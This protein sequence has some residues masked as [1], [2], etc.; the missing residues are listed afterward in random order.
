MIIVRLPSS[1]AGLP[2]YSEM[3][4]TSCPEEFEAALFRRHH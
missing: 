1:L 4:I 3:S 2:T